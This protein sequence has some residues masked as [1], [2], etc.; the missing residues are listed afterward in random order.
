M[1]SVGL[2]F[3]FEHESMKFP[4]SFERITERNSNVCILPAPV[5]TR[6]KRHTN[7][8]ILF[9]V[10][11]NVLSNATWTWTFCLTSVRTRLRTQHERELYHIR[12]NA[13]TNTTRMRHSLF[14]SIQ[15]CFQCHANLHDYSPLTCNIYMITAW[16]CFL[17]LSM[18]LLLW[19]LTF[20]H[21]NLD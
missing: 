7:V 19:R 15:A 21:V 20:K 17:W 13:F 2:L 1:I 10:R 11:S 16:L 4:F 6:D 8:N 14:P 18:W 3:I 12:S 9:H 5:R